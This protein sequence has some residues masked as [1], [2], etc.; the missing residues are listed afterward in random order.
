MNKQRDQWIEM[1]ARFGY[2]AKGVVYLLVGV[3]AAMAAFEGTQPRG[4]EGALQTVLGQPFGKTLLGLIGLGLL[5]YAVWKFVQ[6]VKD[7]EHKGSDASGLIQRGGYLLSGLAHT[8]LAVYAGKQAFTHAPSGGDSAK[9]ATATLMNQPF[10]QWLVATVG[11]VLIAFGL[12]RLYTA[13]QQ[14]FRTKFRLNEMSQT[15]RELALKAGTFG[16]VARSLVFGLTGVLFLSAAFNADPSQAGATRDVLRMVEQQG[17][18]YLVALALG[19][20]AYAVYQGFLARYRR[21]QPAT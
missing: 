15:E 19:L 1:L 12:F 17:A 3:L 5:G 10:G 13:W 14:H 6:A 20:V 21:I 2:L 8:A 18:W 4:S 7:A 11:L 16:I 9:T